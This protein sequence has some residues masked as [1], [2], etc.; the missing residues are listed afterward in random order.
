MHKNI[1]MIMLAV[2]SSSAMT[3]LWKAQAIVSLISSVL[4]IPV[5]RT[6]YTMRCWISD[7][8]MGNGN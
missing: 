7:Q 3:F 1:L 8:S 5:F 6:I 2:V 4:L